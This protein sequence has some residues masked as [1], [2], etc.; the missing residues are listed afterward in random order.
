MAAQHRIAG[1]W[2]GTPKFAALLAGGEGVR[3]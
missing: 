2:T 1:M 3:V